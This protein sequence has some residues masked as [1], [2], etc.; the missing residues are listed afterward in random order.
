M[1]AITVYEAV[2]G[3]RWE[4]EHEA[5][6]RDLHCA[7]LAE[8]SQLIKPV[9]NTTDFRNGHGYVQQ[10]ANCVRAFKT[11]LLIEAGYGN[12]HIRNLMRQVG[13]EHLAPRG[14]VARY[15]DDNPLQ[16]DIRDLW[17]RLKCIDDDFRE[18]G[19]VY[20]AVHPPCGQEAIEVTA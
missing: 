15:L 20:F 17:R 4:T 14:V 8:I 13:P 10:D 16:A 3:S 1:K 9:P 5:D 7:R 19:Q 2:D 11:A 12:E 18:W 6:D